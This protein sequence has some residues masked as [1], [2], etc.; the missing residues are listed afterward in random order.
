MNGS[1]LD[2][3]PSPCELRAKWVNIA[4]LFRRDERI[5]IKNC[6]RSH[7]HFD[8][9][10]KNEFENQGQ[11]VLKTR[12]NNAFI[13]NQQVKPQIANF[14]Y[15]QP[16]LPSSPLLK[17]PRAI[18][19]KVFWCN[20]C[21]HLV[22]WSCQLD[23]CRQRPAPLWVS[24]GFFFIYCLKD[25]GDAGGSSLTDRHKVRP[26]RR[27]VVHCNQLDYP[28]L[29]ENGLDR[30][31]IINLSGTIYPRAHLRATFHFSGKRPRP[32]RGR[33]ASFTKL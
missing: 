17:T 25:S 8:L 22:H 13:V 2:H 29:S 6:S 21:L 3:H 12:E 11:N 15:F 4:S 23:T 30:E 14:I 9:D 32:H 33:P 16:H 24:F 10:K 5:P 31:T 26:A 20:C 27:L 1:I 18:S 7:L 28:S 19:Q